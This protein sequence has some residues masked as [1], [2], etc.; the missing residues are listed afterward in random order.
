MRKAAATLLGLC[1]M[2]A[3]APQAAAGAAAAPLS[4]H[5]QVAR[6]GAGVNVL[7]YDEYWKPGAQGNYREEH[8]RAIREAGFSTVRV[9]L[10]TFPHLDGEGR[11]EPQWLAK[12]DQVV[13]WGRAHDLQMI[14]DVH[15]FMACAEDAASCTG[16]LEK[17]WGQLAARYADQPASLMFELLNEPHGQL[18]VDAWNALLPKLLAVVR[19]TNPTRNVVVGPA[20]WNSFRYLDRLQ[21]PEDDRHLIVTFHYYEPFDFTHQ[22]ASWVEPEVSGLS[23]VRFGNPEQLAQIGRDFDQVQAWSLRHD[24]PVFLGEFGAFD[25]AAMEDRALWTSTVARAAEALGF[26]WAYWQFSS[27]FVV[28]DFQQQAWVQPILKALLPHSPALED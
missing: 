18:D 10:F 4:A 3:G 14:L 17:V 8:F 25:H 28:Y 5:E 23:G 12:L 13:A 15:D 6:M 19:K 20:S 9:V 24:R 16:K 1:M 11:L 21:L 26:A 2:L 7:G 22:G 27:D